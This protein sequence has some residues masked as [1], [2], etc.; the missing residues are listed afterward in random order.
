M[1]MEFF[2]ESGTDEEWHE[3]WLEQRWNWYL[4][5]G[6]REENLRRYEHPKEKLSHYSK[7]TVDIE[8]NY[9][10]AGWS[11]LEGVANRTD[12]DLKQHAEHSGE[13]LEY[14]DQATNRRYYPYVIEPA[15]GPDRVMLAFLRDARTAPAAN[16]WEA[17]PRPRQHHAPAPREHLHTRGGER[18]GAIR[19][20]APP[21]HRADE[22]SRLP[23]LQEGA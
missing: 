5:L 21:P 1:E 13:N 3:Y 8:Y 16:R 22:G 18:R 11:E 19:P 15:V 9:P 2:V 23:P 12:Y 14:I 6:I 17:N 10:F 4:D 20:Q 7:R